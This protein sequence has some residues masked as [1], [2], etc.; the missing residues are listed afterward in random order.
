MQI[1]V[2]RTRKLFWGTKKA[3]ARSHNNYQLQTLEIV[4]IWTT[5]ST[6]IFFWMSFAASYAFGGFAYL[7]LVVLTSVVLIKAVQNVMQP[8]LCQAQS[9]R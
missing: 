1:L 5:F 8:E 3:I 4:M 2:R 6:M 9:I 7:F